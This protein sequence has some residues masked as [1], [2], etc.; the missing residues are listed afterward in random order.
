MKTV[1]TKEAL[2]KKQELEIVEV[3]LGNEECVYVRQMTGHERDQ[4]EQSMRKEIRDKNGVITNYEM[5]LADF[6][7]KLAV[8]TVCDDK[9]ILLLTKNDYMVLSNNMSAQRLETII[10]V[11]QKL[12]AITQ[13]DKEGLIKNLEAV[14]G[15]NSSSGSVEN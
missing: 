3:D 13:E 11:A 5:A 12:N 7:A 2:L 6:R 15:D 14:P 8:S 1:L 10:N 4:F 9:G